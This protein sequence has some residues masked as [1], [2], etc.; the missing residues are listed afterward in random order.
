MEPTILKR[1][2]KTVPPAASKTVAKPAKGKAMI[3]GPEC[4]EHLN[5][6][7]QQED[8]STRVYLAMS[9]WLN[10]MGYLNSAKLWKKYSDEE[11]AHANWAREYLLN[12]GIQPETRMLEAP[13]ESFKGLPEIIRLSYDHEVEITMQVKELADHALKMGNHMLYELALKYNHEQNEELG[14]LQDLIDQLEAFGEDKIAMRLLDH[15][16]K[17]YL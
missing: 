10:N 3:I 12:L 11:Q 9:M 15:E 1:Q 6:R 7:I 2:L 17:D 14:K 8:Y 5:Y 4:I 13:M 16:I